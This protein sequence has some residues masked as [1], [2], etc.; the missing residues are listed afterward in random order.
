MTKQLQQLIERTLTALVST[1]RELAD[2]YMK[3]DKRTRDAKATLAMAVQARN[4]SASLESIWKHDRKGL[5]G[6]IDS[7]DYAPILD[8]LHEVVA[9]KEQAAAR[10]RRERAVAEREAFSLQSRVHFRE[11]KHG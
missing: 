7:P 1:E 11:A 10:H 6:L 3:M 9:A 4:L 8:I 5:L 2:Q